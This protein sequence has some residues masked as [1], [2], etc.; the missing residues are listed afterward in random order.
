[1]KAIFLDIDGVLN[2]MLAP[3]PMHWNSTLPS[4]I[5]V[6]NKIIDATG[7]KIIVISS[8]VDDFYFEGNNPK[9]E[10]FLYE[11]GVRLGSIIGF[12]RDGAEKEE[13]IFES[14]KTNQDIE[15]FIVIDDNP[16]KFTNEFI[17]SR[18]I[19]TDSLEGLVDFHIDIAIR[20][21]NEK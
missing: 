9:L 10:K 5:D 1:M 6:L 8:W 3:G 18:L 16:T 11:R 19:Q 20:M 21:L 12:R 7:A 2:G 17:K 4:C 13:Y 14:I 15:N